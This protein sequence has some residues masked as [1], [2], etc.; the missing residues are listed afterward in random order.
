MIGTSGFC[1]TGAKGFHITFDN[2]VTVSVQFGYGNYC[3][4][5]SARDVLNFTGKVPENCS[6]VDAEIAIWK[7]GGKWITKECTFLEAA[8]DV[9]GNAKPDLV[10]QVLNW[11]KEYK[12]E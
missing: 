11:A 10:L 6:S 5:Y 4:N 1:I 3:A 7:Y 2:G 9:Y 8:D 12:G